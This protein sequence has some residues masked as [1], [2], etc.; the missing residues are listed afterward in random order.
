MQE[1]KI[2]VNREECAMEKTLEKGESRIQ[3]I[4][5]AL[6]QETLEPA[7]EEARQLIESAKLNAAEIVKEAENNSR[8]LLENSK[9]KIEQERNVFQSSMEQAA[10]QSIEELRQNI[11]KKLF[12][13]E[14]E[15]ILSQELTKPNVIAQ[16]ISTMVKAI[17]KDGISADFS[18]IIAQTATPQEINA[19]VGKG[20]VDKLKEKSVVVGQFPG[21]AQLKLHDKK[22]TIDIT[23]TALRELF[24]RY[25]GKEFRKLLFGN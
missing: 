20:I 9:K 4:C 3:K 6:R 11:E 16:L 10:K 14:L 24:S 1:R 13:P 2:L 23:D 25:L 18:A 8:K 12:Q 7:K 17:E 19:L 15:R 5:D 21:G 22:M